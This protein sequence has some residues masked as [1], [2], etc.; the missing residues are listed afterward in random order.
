M[1]KQNWLPV[2]AMAALLYGLYSF[3]FAF[4]SPNLKA[5]HNAQFG[6][7]V[8]IALLSIPINVIGL[9]IWWKKNPSDA[10]VLMSNLSWKLL[11]FTILVRFTIDPIHTVVINSGGSIANQTMYTLAILPVLAGM[12]YFFHERLLKTQWFGLVLAA[13]AMFFMGYTP[14]KIED[15]IRNI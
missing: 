3:S 6:Y 7:G 2:T 9:Y 1:A 13:L 14:G 15:D 12:Y 8:L 10:K 11:L 5:N 4:I